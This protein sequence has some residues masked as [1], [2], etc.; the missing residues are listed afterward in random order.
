[1]TDQRREWS[2]GRLARL[3]INGIVLT[4]IVLEGAARPLYRPLGRRVANLRLIKALERGVARLPPYAALAVLA[5]PFAIADPL[6]IAGLYWMG[7]GHFALGLTT[8][9]FAYGA[10]FVIVERIYHAGRPKLLTI[11]WFATIMAFAASLKDAALARLRT[12][13]VWV[14]AASL[15]VRAKLLAKEMLGRVRRRRLRP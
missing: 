11:K 13:R 14:A 1:M 9:G 4:G 12:T 10:S 7:T 8:L 5:V 15:A 6:K 3:P 2:A